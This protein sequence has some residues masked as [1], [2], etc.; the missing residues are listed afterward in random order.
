MKCMTKN[1]ASRYGQA[2]YDQFYKIVKTMTGK[3]ERH[4]A[5]SKVKADFVAALPEDIRSEQITC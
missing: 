3:H 4:D 5:L 1:F 2:G